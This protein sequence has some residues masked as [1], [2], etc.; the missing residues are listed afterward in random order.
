MIDSGASMQF[1]DLDFV[2]RNNLPLT[3][4]PKPETIIVVNGREA[5]NPLTHTVLT[6]T[7]TWHGAMTF[8]LKPCFLGILHLLHELSHTPAF[9]TYLTNKI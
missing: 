7:L 4:K 2:L 3:L 1:I 6:L 8:F 9:D 5:E